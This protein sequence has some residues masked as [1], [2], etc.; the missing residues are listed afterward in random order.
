MTIQLYNTLKQQKETFTPINPD[1]VT[2]YVCGPTVYNFVHIGNARPV[3]I[4]DTLFRLL[5]RHYPSVKYA[6]NITDV[7][8]KINAAAKTN[9]ETIRELSERYTQAYHE[10]M[11]QLNNLP[12]TLEPRATDNID[13]MIE[14]IQ[15]LI[16]HGHAYESEGHVLFQVSTDKH[17]GQLSHRKLD[18]MIAGASERVDDASYKKEAADF[19]LWKPSTDDL[20]GWDSPW[21]R[22]RPG[23]HIECSAMINK[24]LA[25]TIDIHGGGMDLIF[26]HHENE[27]AQGTCCHADGE[28]Q[29]VRYWMHNG[30]LNIDGQ[31][32]S[33]SLGNFFTVRELLDLWPGEV[34]R[35]ALF[36]AH[37]RKPLDWTK[38]LLSSAKS[39]LDRLYGALRDAPLAVD[40][41]LSH[42]QLEELERLLMDDLATP[43]VLAVLHALAG[44]IN[45]ASGQEK[46][47]LQ[48]VLRKAGS[49]IGLL[50]R[51]AEAWFKWQPA[52]QQG[53]LSDDAIE[54]LIQERVNAKANKN[55]AR[56]DEI[57]TELKDQG[58]T[59][60]DSKDGTRWTRD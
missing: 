22:G 41:S 15:A 16:D 57:R 28:Q 35:Y 29:F 48:Q 18:E 4:F 36:T 19:V 42:P 21:G 25:K 49:F 52:S 50:D 43:Q 2:M 55:F 47:L 44:D 20:P 1:E 24:H 17:Y 6:R 10:D 12:P 46:L 30:Y 39:S 14:Q 8:D 58:I 40:T 5:Q 59:L 38:D 51:D 32:M 33:K 23:W 13:A 34:I 37:Y 60:E 31:K 27:I 9:G 53:G 54:T 56:A 7:D 3:V 26:P 11:G 45:K